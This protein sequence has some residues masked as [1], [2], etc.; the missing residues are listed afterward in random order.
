MEEQVD[1]EVRATIASII[2]SLKQIEIIGPEEL[3]LSGGLVD[4]FDVL[5]LIPMIE[6]RCGVIIDGEHISHENFITINAIAGLV[7]RLKNEETR[8][9]KLR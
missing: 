2:T 6:E 4:S 5:H 7:C 9:R 1:K 3:L 8:A